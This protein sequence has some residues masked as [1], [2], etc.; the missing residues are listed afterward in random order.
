MSANIRKLKI[1]FEKKNTFEPLFYKT[2][3]RGELE[4]TL[5]TLKARMID[6]IRF[7]RDILDKKLLHLLANEAAALAWATAYPL[8][9]FPELFRE[10]VTTALKQV[11]LQNRIRNR[12]A[13]LTS[14]L[15]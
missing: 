2:M 15:V 6:E 8:L 1:E 11:E 14:A 13:V 5:E 3:A 4:S 9:I 10:K 12:S 7:E